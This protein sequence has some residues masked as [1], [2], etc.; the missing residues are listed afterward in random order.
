ML[1]SYLTVFI[2]LGEILHAGSARAASREPSQNFRLQREC[3][4]R[5]TGK[6]RL[7]V[8]E[9]DV[10]RATR[11]WEE[12]EMQTALADDA[13]VTEVRGKNPGAPLANLEYA[14]LQRRLETQFIPRPHLEAALL[15]SNGAGVLRADEFTFG[16]T[17]AEIT[18]SKQD[19]T[20][21]GGIGVIVKFAGTEV[22][23]ATYL[24]SLWP[25]DKMAEMKNS[26][27]QILSLVHHIGW[28]SLAVGHPVAEVALFKPPGRAVPDGYLRHLLRAFSAARFV[29]RSNQAASPLY[30]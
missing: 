26:P 9:I 5:L 28:A 1:K 17:E 16:R 30:E 14:I 29:V 18:F 19:G 3:D 6:L 22:V 27:R 7:R 23:Y 2:L 24:R 20:T 4:E 25:A 13:L 15:R 10:V 11:E 12:A 8:N 21:L